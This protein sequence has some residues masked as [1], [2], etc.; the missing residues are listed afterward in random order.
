MPHHIYT[1]PGFLIHSSPHGES[2]KFFLVFTRDLGMVGATAAGV[3]LSQSKLRYYTQDY[4]FSLFSLVR[5]KD[6]WRMTG[7]KEIEG[8]GEVKEENKKLWVQVLSLLKRLVPGEEQNER[9]FKVIENVHKYLCEN[10]AEKDVVEYLTV[11]RILNVLGYV[12]EQD[13]VG[14]EINSGVL[15]KVKA[16]KE[17]I[18]KMINNGLK[19]S[20][21]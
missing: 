9:L 20:Q 14:E 15:E 5:G 17:A 6:V 2:G 4:S 11:L 3:R 16:Q 13:F 19:Q 10:I 21:L 12:S 8:E 18:L 1:T 7:A